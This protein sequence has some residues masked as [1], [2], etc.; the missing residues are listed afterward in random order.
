MVSAMVGLIA[1][2]AKKPMA[3]K[4]AAIAAHAASSPPPCGEGSGVGVR[5]D[6]AALE[7]MTPLPPLP[8]LWGGGGGGALPRGWRCAQTHAP[9]PRP[10]PQGGRERESVRGSKKITS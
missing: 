7:R 8:P 1:A 9:P 4:R 10:P 2:I 6:G 3:R 5:E